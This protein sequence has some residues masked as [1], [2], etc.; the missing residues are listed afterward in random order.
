M[1]KD[2]P[3]VITGA[4]GFIGQ[5]LIKE[6]KRKGCVV[7]AVSRSGGNSIEGVHNIIVKDYIDTPCPE[8][9]ILIHLA[10]VRSVTEAYLLGE[11]RISDAE[12]SVN[13]IFQ[14]PFERKIFISSSAVYD[15]NSTEPKTVSSPV[16]DSNLY[17]KGKLACEKCVID[18]GGTVLRLA[19]VIGPGMANFNV[20]SD[21]L[22]QIPGKG[23]IKV[24]NTSAVRDFIDIRDVVSAIVSI[25]YRVGLGIYNIG[26][27]RGISVGDLASKVMEISGEKAREI[28]STEAAQDNSCIILDITETKK[29]FGW[30][31][32]FTIDL[33]IKNIISSTR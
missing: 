13:T 28:I 26:S 2:T 3:V 27:G 18:N 33:S 20:L 22:S 9:S 11:K 19:N 29:L 17:I 6:F 30:Q 21:I 7:Y 10:D 15:N 32:E 5:Y 16:R 24:M 14:K 4:S 23:P 25:A 8:D 31:P 12:N 1:N